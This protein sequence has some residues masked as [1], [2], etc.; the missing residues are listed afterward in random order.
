MYYKLSGLITSVCELMEIMRGIVENN[1]IY[2]IHWEFEISVYHLYRD[3]LWEI[4]LYIIIIIN[5]TV[6]AIHWKIHPSTTDHLFEGSVGIIQKHSFGYDV[7]GNY[8]MMK[9]GES[10]LITDQNRH[11]NVMCNFSNSQ[12]SLAFRHIMIKS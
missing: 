4:P 12:T 7:I 6:S 5:H 11:D 2:T 8:L 3:S 9:H 1:L 10:S